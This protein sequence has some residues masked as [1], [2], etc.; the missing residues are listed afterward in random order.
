MR[1]SC[2]LLLP[3]AAGLAAPAFA[4]PGASGSV[5][6]WAVADALAV[7]DDAETSV[8]VSDR[9]FDRARIAGDR[10][11]DILDSAAHEETGGRILRIQIDAEGQL[12]SL[13][14]GGSSSYSSDMGQALA[15]TTNT[16]DRLA[17][18]FVY[19]A[20][21]LEFDLPVWRNGAIPRVGTALPADGGEPGAALR[22]FFAAI[23]SGDFDAF[24]ALSP[25]AWRE[26][27][28]A[29]KAKGEAQL[30][31]DAVAGEL[32][33]EPTITGGHGEAQRAWVDLSGHREG[34]PVKAVATLERDA[35]GWYVR[36]V[37]TLP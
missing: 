36:R 3:L 26:S 9:P 30:E 12:S 22:A 7:V 27:M 23:A 15:L 31:I 28:Q 16:A 34:R 8:L 32:P 14:M 21:Q 25:P 20:T 24:V 18:R 1:P 6:G 4:K 5:D 10:R 13:G 35:D 11:F 19:G 29:S 17:G 2:L 37:D 33:A